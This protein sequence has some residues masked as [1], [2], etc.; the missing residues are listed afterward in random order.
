MAALVGAEI[1]P[2]ALEVAAGRT[3][4]VDLELFSDV[5]EIFFA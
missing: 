5:A 2:V 3:R 4:P 1:S